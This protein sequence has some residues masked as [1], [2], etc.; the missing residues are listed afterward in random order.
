[1][2]NPSV[3]LFCC[4]VLE[5]MISNVIVLTYSDSS[6]STLSSNQTNK[7]IF[8]VH[9]TNETKLGKHHIQDRLS[10]SS[11]RLPKRHKIGRQYAGRSRNYKRER[12]RHSTRVQAMR[13][14]TI[15]LP[16]FETYPKIMYPNKNQIQQNLRKKVLV[17]RNITTKRKGDVK[18]SDGI[19]MFSHYIV[20]PAAFLLPPYE[21]TND[22]SSVR[23]IHWQTSSE[24]YTTESYYSN[25][26]ALP[27]STENIEL[28]MSILPVIKSL[29]NS[30]NYSDQYFNT[31][32]ENN[33]VNASVSVTS[34]V[35][36]NDFTSTVTP[37]Q[38]VSNESDNNFNLLANDVA[39]MGM[40]VTTSEKGIEMLKHFHIVENSNAIAEKN[41]PYNQISLISNLATAETGDYWRN[42]KNEPVSGES[43]FGFNIGGSLKISFIKK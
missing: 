28:T 2:N 34:D 31:T 26:S 1:M 5:V 37:R 42:Y 15:L 20:P 7:A 30:L 8:I 35:Q 22:A 39:S 36:D 21:D 4:F 29:T 19:N 18:S 41:F 23:K 17:S 43:I 9:V 11:S 24:A 12:H 13:P 38:D 6:S 25:I 14:A 16:P 10:E 40:K 32:T 27:T 33:I 3:P